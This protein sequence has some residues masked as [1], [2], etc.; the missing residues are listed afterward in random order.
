MP[1]ECNPRAI[2]GIPLAGARAE[3]ARAILGEGPPLHVTQGLAYLGPAM[4][5]LGAPLALSRGQWGRWLADL[6]RG[7]D[8]LA[9]GGDRGPVA[10]ALVDAARFAWTGLSRH[11]SPT[12]QTTDDIEWN[13]EPI[14]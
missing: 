4:V 12:R 10:G 13:G 14:Q 7:S 11:R 9:R 6:R 5:L 8:A 2:S 3:L 1:I